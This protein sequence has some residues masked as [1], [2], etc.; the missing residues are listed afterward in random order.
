MVDLHCH[1]LPN[2]DDGPATLDETLTMARF[3]V[4][5]G[6]TH[7]VA[8]P[9]CHPHVHLLRADVLPQVAQ[10][11]LTARHLNPL[12]PRW[13]S[14]RQRNARVR[15]ID[16]ETPFRRDLIR[17]QLKNLALIRHFHPPILSLDSQ[18]IGRQT[19]K[20]QAVSDGQP[21]QFDARPSKSVVSDSAKSTG[22]R[23]SLSYN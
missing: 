10:R 20:A 2:V 18:Y 21:S 8:T 6:I 19:T 16:G 17:W 5:D 14:A 23:I 3:C 4:E 15:A 9:D 7:V 13:N 22:C 1:I 11:P 12:A